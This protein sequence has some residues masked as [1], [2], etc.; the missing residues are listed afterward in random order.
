MLII[1]CSVSWQEQ[2]IAHAACQL[3][4]LSSQSILLFVAL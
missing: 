1:V 3:A 2:S 4:S